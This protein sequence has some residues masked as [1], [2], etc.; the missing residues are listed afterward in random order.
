MA[1][2]LGAEAA[3]A[4][5][6][7]L[8]R[9]VLALIATHPNADSVLQLYEH[10][11]KGGDDEDLFLPFDDRALAYAYSLRERLLRILRLTADKQR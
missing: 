8:E 7:E 11:S 2:K 4:S 10:V 1:D 5:V 6:R 9:V 3:L